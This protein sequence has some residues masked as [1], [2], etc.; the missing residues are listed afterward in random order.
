MSLHNKPRTETAA[1]PPHLAEVVATLPPQLKAL[2]EAL[3]RYL[4]DVL[5]NTPVY[6]DRRSGADLLEQYLYP[7][8]HRTLEVWPV[9]WRH[10][11]GKAITLTVVL[12]AVGYARLSSAPV[13][14]GGHRPASQRKTT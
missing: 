9:L 2:V 4:V 6:S 14:M 11:N 13:I 3:P 7:V 1:L 8:S 12:F 5:A 10:V